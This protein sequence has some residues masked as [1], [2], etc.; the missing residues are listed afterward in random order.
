MAKTPPP[1]AKE[2]DGR[3]IS[4]SDWQ[5]LAALWPYVRPYRGWLIAALVA[6]A[7]SGLLG[8][9]FPWILGTLVDSAL[10]PDSGDLSRS[11]LLLIGIFAGQAILAG[12][13][14]RTLAHAGQH[15]VNDI[16]SAL[17]NRM[18]RFPLAFL[19]SRPSGALSSRLI[20]DAAF[21]YGSVS[22][23]GPQLVYSGITVIGGAVLLIAI[24]L[25]L[26]LIVLA[27]VPI[28]VVVGAKYGTRMRD[29]SR[30]YQNGLA[31]TNALAADALSGARVVKWFGAERSLARNYH[32]RLQGVIE[33]GLNRARVK[34]RWTPAMMFLASA[35][36]V[37]VLW[38]G[39]SQVRSGTL[40]AG[41]LVSFLL[42]ARFV[43]E[44]LS[45]IVDQYSRLAQ[46]LG[47][48]E[49]VVALLAEPTEEV[50]GGNV[51]DRGNTTTIP[52]RSGAVALRDVTFS[53]PGRD[54]VVLDHITLTIEPGSTVALVGPSGAGKSTIAQLIARL[55]DPQAGTVSV[56]GLDVREQDLSE[57]RSSMG[58]VPQDAPMLSSSI[59]DN[60]RLGRPD[61]SREEVADAARTANA[62]EFITAFP[63]GFG[64]KVGE[65]GQSLSGGQRQRI[66]IARAVLADPSLLVLDEA[67][68]ALD[69]DSEALVHEALDR[70]MSGRTNLVIAHRLATVLSADQIIVLDEG[71]IVETGSPADLLA[72]DTRFAAM[73]AAQSLGLELP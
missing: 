7:V 63:H 56:D 30:G 8:L 50:I 1:T 3:R 15:A 12:V 61:A 45:T 54:A 23:A 70:L 28:A 9:G 40:T 46:G 24:D 14:I 41:E 11:A 4:S 68:N 67:T 17:F 47:A 22:G 58:V 64:T 48:S 59:A 29:L 62:W 73:A 43:A 71:R 60:I 55:Y 20:S 26:S 6:T 32:Q 42:Y 52:D 36:I 39:G 18:I 27:A 10:D 53:Y 19:D 13:R 25:P 2:S 72:T 44:G 66:A 16:R 33:Q 38:L 57:L 34:S 49:R 31:S 5:L 51:T 21:V 35:T 65:R 69:S 37:A